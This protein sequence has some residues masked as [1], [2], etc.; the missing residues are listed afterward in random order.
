MIYTYICGSMKYIYSFKC[1]LN[2]TNMVAKFFFIIYATIYVAQFYCGTYCT[3]HTHVVKAAVVCVSACFPFAT[4]PFQSKPV[5]CMPSRD[6]TMN[7]P[8]RRLF[9]YKNLWGLAIQE[10]RRKQHGNLPISSP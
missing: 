3:Y 9:T 8:P 7:I 1:T 10:V 6:T 2:C 5:G 4:C